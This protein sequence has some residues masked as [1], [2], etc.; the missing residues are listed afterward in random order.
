MAQVFVAGP[1]EIHCGV[2]SGGGLAFLG[3]S[4]SGVRISENPEWDDVPADLSG[5]RVPFD[6]QDMSSQAYISCDL[7]V[8]NMAVYN[9]I[10][11]RFRPQD[12]NDPG[13]IPF[14]AVGSLMLAEGSAYRLLIYP[15]YIAKP[16]M[17]TLR[18]YNFYAGWLA[19]PD[20][21]NPFGTKAMKVRT[22]FRSIPVYN[23]QNG[24]F[25]LYNADASGKP[26]AI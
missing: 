15:P 18:P 17:A 4:E 13:F 6:V 22:I 1:A 26:P 8:W 9:Q 24:N 25:G 5:S 19:G 23:P 12:Q 16:A 3:W 14:G 7:K 21:I 11:A 2:A 10:A 20:D